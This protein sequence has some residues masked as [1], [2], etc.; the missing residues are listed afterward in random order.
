MN[1]WI[2]FKNGTITGFSNTFYGECKNNQLV[3]NVDGW[4]IIFEHP[5]EQLNENYFL[6]TRC[7]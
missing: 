6:L 1:A 5:V 2:F 7:F 3:T 4:K